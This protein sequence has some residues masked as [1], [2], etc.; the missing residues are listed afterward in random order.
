MFS[1]PPCSSQL[2]HDGTWPQLVAIGLF[3]C[4][5]ASLPGLGRPLLRS[6]VDGV[7]VHGSMSRGGSR[8]GVGLRGGPAGA[9]ARG[10]ASSARTSEGA[11]GGGLAADSSGVEGIPPVSSATAVAAGA[12]AEDVGHHMPQ[13][14]DR[15]LAGAGSGSAGPA[16]DGAI[17]PRARAPHADEMDEIES[18]VGVVPASSGVG[19]GSSSVAV[20]EEHG[21]VDVV[22]HMVG[23]VPARPRVLCR[24]ARTSRVD[25]ICPVQ[26]CTYTHEAGGDGHECVVS[27]PPRRACARW[28]VSV[29]AARDAAGTI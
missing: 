27:P 20:G 25:C 26:G 29:A 14:A 15:D 16:A 1:L 21:G 28:E 3:V 24:A 17:P 8:S 22:E 23:V 18:M 2:L 7:M 5:R 13:T 10:G 4:V 6:R 19:G 12:E 9:R 11:V